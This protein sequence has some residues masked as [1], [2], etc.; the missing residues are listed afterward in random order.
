MRLIDADKLIKDRVENDLVRIAVM[1]APTAYDQDAIMEQIRQ[2][3]NVELVDDDYY[4]RTGQQLKA[5]TIPAVEKIIK[6]G[7]TDD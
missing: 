2:S 3:A 1:G 5:I 4:R 6:A 7:G